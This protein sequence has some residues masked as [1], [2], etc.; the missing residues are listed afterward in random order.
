MLDALPEVVTVTVYDGATLTVLL[1]HADTEG[2][3]LAVEDTDPVPESETKLEAEALDDGDALFDV[4]LVDELQPVIVGLALELDVPVDDAVLDSVLDE[5]EDE[6]AVAV[7]ELVLDGLAVG[8]SELEALPE[9]VIINEYDD[10]PLFDVLPHEVT[11]GEALVELVANSVAEED[12]QPDT[13]T[14]GDDDEVA[15]AELVDEPV[16]ELDP[17]AVDDDVLVIELE[18]DADDEALGFVVN[19]PV[20]ETDADGHADTDAL[21]VGET[22]P[23]VDDDGHPDTD[24]LGDDE[25]VLELELDDVLVDVPEAVAVDD[26]E[27]VD[28]DVLDPV[29]DELDES[30]EVDDDEPV[31]V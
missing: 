29:L 27:L 2:E 9:L 30:V 7:D 4:A 19:V 16:D 18:G 13:D 3:T 5:L 8:L 14:L 15:E 17:V 12:R 28:D 22:E 20:R 23:V 6:D 24:T 21:C 31:L 1:P 25:A 11:E 26:T 10:E